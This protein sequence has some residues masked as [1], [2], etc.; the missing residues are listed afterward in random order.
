[1]NQSP[2]SGPTIP[3]YN[4]QISGNEWKYVKECLDTAWVSSVGS[5]VTRFEQMMA[6]RADTEF[7]VAT[8]NGTSALH[9]AMLAA[10]I[11]PEDEVLVSSLTFI[12]SANAIRYANAWPVFVD[13][14]PRHW[15][16]DV[17]LVEDFLANHCEQRSGELRNRRTGRRVSAIMPVHVLGHP[18]DMDPLLELAQR[19]GL[20]VVEDAAEGLGVTYKGRPAGSMS[21][22]GC[23]SFNGNKLITT[24]AGGVVLTN[25]RELAARARHLTTQAK[26]D[27]NEYV[28]DEVGYNFRMCNVLAAIGCAQLEQ[29][30]DFIARKRE[31]ARQYA[32]QLSGIDGIAVFEV[33][34]HAYCTH[35]LNTIRVS[36]S[37]CGMTARELGRSLQSCGIQNRPL[38][39]PMHR[40]PAHRQC[41][42]VLSGVADQLYD[43]CLSLPSSVGLTSE[44]VTLVCRT[45][46]HFLTERRGRR[47]A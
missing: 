10:G 2:P 8:V 3:L 47:A 9:V 5:F 11:Q 14:E 4:P 24:G 33:S 46:R 37:H 1:M 40:S 41:E 44:E 15:Q 17:E 28:H 21:H 27:P 34:P 26:C 31:Q 43:E 13:A 32:E 18:V 39:Q 20:T 42:A 30:D 12:A 36:A 29:L 16:M 19:Y 38:W 25:D 7:A 22:V 6:H 35:W 45:I 23:V